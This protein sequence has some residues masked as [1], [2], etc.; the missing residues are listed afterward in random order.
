MNE[1]LQEENIAR[2]L[3]FFEKNWEELLR[4]SRRNRSQLERWAARYGYKDQPKEI[5][6]HAKK[7]SYAQ[8]YT[9]VNLQN[10]NTIEFRIFRG[11]LKYNTFIAILQLVNKVC[12]VAMRLSDEEMRRLTWLKFVMMCQE[13]ELIQYLKERRLYVNEE[14]SVGQEV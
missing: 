11:T 4:F 2:V 5:L 6:D 1:T 7:G 10:T 8:C 13:P 14:V 3:Y 12:E 9:C